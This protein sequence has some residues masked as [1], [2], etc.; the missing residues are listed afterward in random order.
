MN[1]DALKKS[2]VLQHPSNTNYD[3]T[4]NESLSVAATRSAM[5]AEKMKEINRQARLQKEAIEA[6]YAVETIEAL[7]SRIT[8]MLAQIEEAKTKLADKVKKYGFTGKLKNL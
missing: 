7:D 1:N 5:K 8:A 2:E 3:N 4:V 6:E